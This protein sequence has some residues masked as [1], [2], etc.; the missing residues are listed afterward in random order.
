[1]SIDKKK[2]TLG[3]VLMI[4]F[5]VVFVILCLPVFG[6]MNGMAYMDNLYNSISKGSAYYIPESRELAKGMQGE[7]IDFDLEF[8]SAIQAERVAVI[9]NAHG[10]Q[11][12]ATDTAVSVKGDLGLLM[13]AALDDA[14][15][16]YNN[17]GKA[18]SDRY[19]FGERAAMYNWWYFTENLGKKL[20][21]DKR[22]ELSKDIGTIKSKS[23]EATYNFYGIEP[24]SITDQLWI[25]IGSLLFYVI[26][27]LW[28][29][30]AILFLFEG[31]GFDLEHH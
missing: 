18:L 3:S 19:G 11:A 2:I 14:D 28:Y 4:S 24:Q 20:N 5:A 6:G 27:T 7:M 17:D 23:I 21:K 13:D 10:A 22:F 8:K 31:A 1:M 25:V 9:L 15:S 12:T 26:Y 16:M 30:F 29:G